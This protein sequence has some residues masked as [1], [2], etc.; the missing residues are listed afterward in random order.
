MSSTRVALETP[1]KNECLRQIEPR[2]I[3][4]RKRKRLLDIFCSGVLLLLLFPLLLAIAV[5]I[6]ATSKGPVFYVTQRVGFMGRSFPFYKFRSM[7]TDAE[8]RLS[9]LKA[10]NEKDGPIFK[11]KN[12][13]RITPVGRFLRK[14]SLDELPQ[15][16]SVFLGHMSMVG[17]RPQLP[18]EV[19][20]YDEFAAQRL[21]VRPG[22][23]CYWQIMGR[24]DL[25][26]E[27]WME[28]DN[29]YLKEMGVWT[30]LKI[31]AKTPM[32]ILRGDGAY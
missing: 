26:F 6:K 16:I 29:R 30:D 28:L 31:L 7:Y 19:E 11:M 14:Y 10:Q 13:P 4:Y 3:T 25:T 9:E 2:I 15:L 22:L 24:S 18:A 23:T 1:I 17:P 27:E 21:S 32:A 12:D 20:C 5:L 8:K